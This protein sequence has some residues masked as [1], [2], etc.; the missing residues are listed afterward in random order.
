MAQPPWGPSS[1][2]ALAS[3]FNRQNPRDSPIAAT[4]LYDP[5]GL[6]SSIQNGNSNGSHAEPAAAAQGIRIRQDVQHQHQQP[7]SES[8][9]SSYEDKRG[10]RRRS[11]EKLKLD[12][13]EQTAA[14]P[15]FGRSPSFG[16]S[17]AANFL[18]AFSSMNTMVAPSHAR[19]WGSSS[20]DSRSSSANVEPQRSSSLSKWSKLPDLTSSPTPVTGFQGMGGVAAQLMAKS[21]SSGQLADKTHA[22]NPEEEGATFGPDDRY[23]LGRVVGF[24]GFSTI[25]EGWDLAEERKGGGKHKVAVKLVYRDPPSSPQPEEAN[26]DEQEL[27][28]WRSLPSHPNLLPLLYDDTMLID[29]S[30][31]TSSTG[32]LNRDPQATQQELQLL[33]M[34]LCEGGN[35]MDFVRGEGGRRQAPS[36]VQSISLGRSQSLHQSP[37]DNHAQHPRTGSGFLSRRS[38][39]AS[40]DV[41]PSSSLALAR[42]PSGA[43][44]TR[45]TSSAIPRSQGIDLGAARDILRQLA[46]GL[47]CLHTKMNVLH[48][49]LKLENVLAQRMNSNGSPDGGG[50]DG[51]V[52]WRLADFGLSQ[53]VDVEGALTQQALSFFKKRAGM[54]SQDAQAGRQTL[55]PPSRSLSRAP[56]AGAGAG[57]LAYTPPEMWRDG[58]ATS[59]P[60]LDNT[61][62]ASPFA[63]D[64]WALG[65]IT[66]ALLSGKMPFSDA[67]EP[68][69]QA[70]IAKGEWE[71]P[72]RLWRRA[73]RLASESFKSDGSLSRQA[74]GKNMSRAGSF[75]SGS[76]E[77]QPS[78]SSS[79]S[80]SR[81]PSLAQFTAITDL[82][83]SLPY[84]PDSG[85][86]SARYVNHDAAAA[87]DAPIV[88]SAPTKPGEPRRFDIDTIAQAAAD[89]EADPE[90]DAEASID[91]QWDGTSNERAAARAVL[92]GLLDPEPSRRWTV[93]RLLASRWLASSPDQE[94]Q[95]PFITNG[96]ATGDR[97]L[98]NLTEGVA[99][100]GGAMEEEMR[101]QHRRAERP[102]WG[103][104]KSWRTEVTF[105]RQEPAVDRA[106]RRPSSLSRSRPR[107]D[108]EGRRSRSVS[109][110]REGN[111]RNSVADATTI[112]HDGADSPMSSRP[113]PRSA[114]P[115]SPVEIRGRRPGPKVPLSQVSRE[116]LERQ[117]EERANDTSRGSRAPSVQP[118]AIGGPKQQPRS[119]ELE[120]HP[121]ANAAAASW[122]CYHVVQLCLVDA[123]IHLTQQVK[124]AR[125]SFSY[126]GWRSS[127]R[128]AW[129]WFVIC[130][131]SK[132]Q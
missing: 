117:L 86:K 85:Y 130:F 55:P 110:S 93:Q 19:E 28:I 94:R 41:T 123:S 70:K 76:H 121:F 128:W 20:A 109:V 112:L 42:S 23:Q 105:E 58:T 108:G 34:P 69:L 21:D 39:A 11:S 52:C 88:G 25:R 102:Q 10:R 27:S 116:D 47:L 29:R 81:P 68:R 44:V 5:S 38:P 54:S 14:S 60:G 51:A 120:Q 37:N 2:S 13:E 50:K 124:G 1:T 127:S 113:T 77:R 104:E 122:S 126:P 72:P 98:E 40:T 33:V 106:A 73:R 87:H 16:R 75:G 56:G 118:I 95:N 7:P 67:F 8:N 132:G 57:S 79:L 89:A 129:R 36:R 30:D 24:G 43:G 31:M 65:C 63:S 35:L 114:T 48:G 9:S 32:S 49:D 74:S 22:F 111:A 82:S 91:Q 84:L 115:S 59:S 101:Q 119:C 17:P 99:V 3:E 90:S 125:R 6:S 46:E 64:M 15:G 92:R 83:A 53:R 78:G 71:L 45:R 4:P 100:G 66:Y 131:L 12:M 103:R 61:E 26:S 18:S 97:R 80:R 107:G 62:E 96:G